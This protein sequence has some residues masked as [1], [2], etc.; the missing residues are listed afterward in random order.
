MNHRQQEVDLELQVRD[1]D[2][3][4]RQ[5]LEPDAGRQAPPDESSAVPNGSAWTIPLLCLGLGIIAMALVI[6]AADENRRLI[7]E[8]EKL[9]A[10]LAHV[11]KQIAINDEF[12]A[13]LSS[14]PGL[15]ER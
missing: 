7:Y 9:A 3:M 4:R 10:E 5:W 6:P 14:D 2:L 1:S 15:A 12:L 11:Q 13:R 8:R